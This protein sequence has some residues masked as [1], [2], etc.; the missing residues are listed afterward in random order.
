MLSL[1]G[2]LKH[3][4]R[5]KYIFCLSEAPCLAP[6]LLFFLITC[7]GIEVT[8]RLFWSN[9][10][11]SRRLHISSTAAIDYSHFP[12]GIAVKALLFGRIFAKLE[13]LGVVHLGDQI[14]RFFAQLVDLLRL[15]QILKEGFF[16]RVVLE[17][18]DQLFDFVF[19]ICI[20]LLNCKK[21]YTRNSVIHGVAPGF[22]GTFDPLGWS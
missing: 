9:R 5:M 12:V 20:L 15:A 10:W 21:R 19:T 16:V 22:P 4:L 6:R 1:S 3:L 17:L 14:L 11:T 2:F 18:L 7:P 13:D 8:S